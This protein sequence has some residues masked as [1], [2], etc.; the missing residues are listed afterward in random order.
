MLK[1]H[2]AADENGGLNLSEMDAIER[3]LGDI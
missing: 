2:Y 1:V 3:D